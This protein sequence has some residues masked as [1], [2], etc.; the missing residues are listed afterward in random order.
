[1]TEELRGRLDEPALA[2]VDAR[3]LPAVQRLARRRRRSRRPHPRRGRVSRRVG[4]APRRR[5]PRRLLV[6]EGRRPPTGGRGLRRRRGRRARSAARRRSAT[7]ASGSTRTGRVGSRTR[8]S[9]SSGCR[10][11]RGSSTSTG[12]ARCSPASA[13]RP[14]RAAGSSSSTSTSASPRSTRRATSPAR[15][16]STR[17]GSRTRVDWN[18]RSPEE[19]EAALRRAR[20]HARHDGRPLRP[21]HR[22]RREREVAGPARR[23]DRRDPRGADPA[24]RRRR[25]RPAARRRLRPLGPRRATRSRPTLRALRRSPSFGAAI[26]QRPEVIVDIERGEGDPRRPG[27]RGARQRPDV[28]RAHRRGQRLQLHRPGGPDRRRRLGQLRLR[29]VPH[30]ALPQRRQHD[31]RLP[32]DRRQLGGGR[33]HA[34]QVGRLLLRHR[35][36]RERDVVLR[37]PHGLAASRRLRRRLVRVEQGPERNPIEIGLETAEL[38]A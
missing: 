15:S 1:M 12:S 36:A 35:L 27:R 32:G 11:T 6:D 7:R 24:L 30:A 14:R 18:R 20:H 17:T 31:A 8:P 16:T 26:P 21:R 10:T 22:G 5:R 23:P 25:R 38:A 37:L 34:G 28:A 33:H 13:P 9:R 29:R 19:L 3:P 4:A 2:I